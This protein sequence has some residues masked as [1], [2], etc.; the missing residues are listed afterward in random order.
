MME[1]PGAMPSC[2]STL[3]AFATG[4]NGNGPSA[5]Q[6][7]IEILRNIAR[8]DLSLGKFYS[9]EGPEQRRVELLQKK[10][11]AMSRRNPLEEIAGDGIGSAPNRLRYDEALT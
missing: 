10:R 8:D 11:N 1:H 4:A 9:N 7:L 3:K 5:S 6:G 2:S